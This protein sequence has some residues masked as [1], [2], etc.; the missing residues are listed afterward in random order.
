MDEGQYMR[1]GEYRAPP[2]LLRELLEAGETLASIARKHGVEVHRVR[3]R[4]RRLGLGELKGKAP[5]R[6]ALAL[7]LSH[8]DIPLTRIA[9]A[10][11]CEPCTIGVAARRYGLP[12]DEAGRRALMEARS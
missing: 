1:D 4:C 6:D 12:T 7:A 2:A 8:S 11:G 5:A 3:Y 9:K 10:F